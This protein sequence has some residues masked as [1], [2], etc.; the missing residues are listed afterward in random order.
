MLIIRILKYRRLCTFLAWASKIDTRNYAT[1]FTYDDK[2]RLTQ[3]RDNQYALSENDYNYIN[4]SAS[5][6]DC[7]F[8]TV[9]TNSYTYV[10]TEN[11]QVTYN[12]PSGLSPV[13]K[14]KIS[15]GEG[16][17]VRGTR[18][19]SVFNKQYTTNGLKIIRL[20]LYLSDGSFITG[21]KNIRIEEGT[22]AGSNVE[23]KN[24][25]VVNARKKSARICGDPG[26]IVTH[27][28]YGGSRPDQVGFISVS[29]EPH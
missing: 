26:S 3:V 4:A 2:E 24:I 18:I 6:V 29:E 12:F 9:N 15:Y 27:R 22:V 28:K 19:R 10:K 17:D 1:H 8:I 25:V 11:I 21:H 23:F 20:Y 7:H 5:C 13:S 16:D 14:W